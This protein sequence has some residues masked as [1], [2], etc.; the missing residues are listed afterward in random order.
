MTWRNRIANNNLFISIPVISDEGLGRMCFQLTDLKASSRA[1]LG[2]DGVAPA[3]SPFQPI[4]I[5][6]DDI[7]AVLL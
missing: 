7:F 4:V 6:Y 1:Y 5:F 2:G 3:A